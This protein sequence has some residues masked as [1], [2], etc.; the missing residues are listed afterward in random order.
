MKA[1]IK[2]STSE[3]V[4]REI[5]NCFI[6]RENSKIPYYLTAILKALPEFNNEEYRYR[7]LKSPIFRGI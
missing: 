1:L 5:N 3:T 2:S 7:N 6:K 4:N